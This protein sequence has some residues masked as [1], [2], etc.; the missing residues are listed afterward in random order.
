MAHNTLE[1][2]AFRSH[3]VTYVPR[4]FSMKIQVAQFPEDQRVVHEFTSLRRQ[5]QLSSI[6]APSLEHLL[7]DHPQL[8]DYSQKEILGSQII[9]AGSTIRLVSSKLP[10]DAEVGIQFTLQNTGKLDRYMNFKCRVRFHD[11][12]KLI[13]AKAE[14]KDGRGVC[15]G[16]EYEDTEVIDD[17]D[18]SPQR[19]ELGNVHFGSGLWAKKLGEGMG[20]LRQANDHLERAAQLNGQEAMKAEALA[21]ELKTNLVASFKNL[22]ALQEISATV[23]STGKSERLLLICWR[24]E[25]CMNEQKPGETTWRNI[26]VKQLRAAPGRVT[27]PGTVPYTPQPVKEEHLSQDRWTEDM[28]NISSTAATVAVTLQQPFDSAQAYALPD[29]STLAMPSVAGTE[30]QLNSQYYTDNDFDFSGHHMQLNLSQQMSDVPM[31][32]VD[33]FPSQSTNLDDSNMLYV[34]NSNWSQIQY[35]DPYFSQNQQTGYNGVQTYTE[36]E[37]TPFSEAGAQQHTETPLEQMPSQHNILP[38]GLQHIFAALA[39]ERPLSPEEALRQ[40]AAY[41]SEA[42]PQDAGPQHLDASIEQHGVIQTSHGFGVEADTESRGPEHA[43]QS[44][45]FTS[46]MAM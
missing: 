26:I 4:N 32:L 43:L 18:Y 25:L 8:A 35:P 38:D 5:A 41:R 28:M 24:F 44:I 21:K 13:M 34:Q 29:F 22:T 33:S 16:A 30:G 27:N 15:A 40:H 6:T 19:Q 39:P 1:S 46:Q 20:Q 3:Y 9:S 14:R 36:H 23:R 42:V 37:D 7:A 17:V 2:N 10:N 45:E 31:N 11:P 12:V